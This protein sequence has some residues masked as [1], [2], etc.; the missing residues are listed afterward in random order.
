M[1]VSPTPVPVLQSPN[2]THRMK[3]RQI[4][5]GGMKRVNRFV[6]T[7]SKA[8]MSTMG[9]ARAQTGLNCGMNRTV[10]EAERKWVH[11]DVCTIYNLQ[12]DCT[13]Y[14][15]LPAKL[16]TALS[17]ARHYHPLNAIL[18]NPLQRDSSRTVQYRSIDSTT[19]AAFIPNW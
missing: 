19:T 12:Q 5:L 17:N 6:D 3:N 2:E 4:V 9:R 14:A 1:E 16:H 7:L 15:A 11:S 13:I 18:P 8:M 10:R